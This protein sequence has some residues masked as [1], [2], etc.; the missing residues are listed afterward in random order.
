VIDPV[1]TLTLRSLI[2]QKRTIVLLV[3]ALA[4][5]LMALAYALGRSPGDHDHS[6][7]SDLV[8]Q[9]FVPT[10]ASLIAL[11]FGVSAFGDE[12][13]DGTILYLVAT[14]QSR[15]RLV[16]AKVAAAWTATLALLV[17]SLVAS[18]VLS[19]RHGLTAALVGWPLAGVV[20]A[21]LA[22]CGASVLLSL[23]TRRPIVI[24]VLYILL[25]E[26]SI[27]TFAASAAKL[28]I[29]AYGRAFVGHVLPHAS[30]P[31]AGTAVATLVLVAVTAA[32]TWAAARAL[33]RVE[34]P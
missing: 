30:P 16:L 21:S 1:Y 15:I 17:P 3:V 33:G 14:P 4:P 32:A 24:G 10:V 8:Q 11:V 2:L 26:G 19:L 6:F 20:L 31:V 5:V 28:S 12:R 34:L 18:G 27:A 23:Y 13:E 29:S 22:Y 25:W 9:L 7:Y